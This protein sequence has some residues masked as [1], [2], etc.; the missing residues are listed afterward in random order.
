[1]KL[2]QSYQKK[3]A[4]VPLNRVFVTFA[5]DG[6]QIAEEPSFGIEELSN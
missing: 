5:K 4:G 2:R 1:L 6:L 3:F